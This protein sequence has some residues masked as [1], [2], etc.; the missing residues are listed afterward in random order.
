M[1]LT[2]K[3][4]VAMGLTEEQV[5][6]IIEM[7]TE[8]VDGLKEQLKA[9]NEKAEKLDGVEKELDA[10]KAKGESE[11]DYKSRY[12]SEHKAFEDYK[13]EQ[14]ARETQA[15]REKAA[16]SYFEAH[17]ITGANLEIAMR[18]SRDEISSIDL[19]GETIKDAAKLD[20]LVK[21]TFSGLVVTKSKTGAPTATPP[22]NT[23]GGMTKE[24]I[25][26]IKD[27]GLRQQA[28]A[29]HLNLFRRG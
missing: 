28:I 29:E 10:L 3:S 11:D 12:Q 23:G 13:K 16:R 26:K 17:G 6:S 14:A 22:A 2:R 18:G 9:A 19:D 8:T 20:E 7:H 24:D 1:A 21:G 27:T 4:L 5:G 15:A 25:L